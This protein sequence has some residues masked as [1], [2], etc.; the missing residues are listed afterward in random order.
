MLWAIGGSSTP[1]A[2][3]LPAATQPR[4]GARGLLAFSKP[5]S[6]KFY[7]CH[8]R[9]EAQFSIC[10]G[11][12]NAFRFAAVAPMEGVRVMRVRCQRSAAHWIPADLQWSRQGLP[13]A[14]ALRSQRGP[15][16]HRTRSSPALS[17]STLARPCARWPPRGGA[18]RCGTFCAQ[19]V[20]NCQAL[21]EAGTGL[22]QTP[23]G[24][25]GG[26]AAWGEA[27]APHSE[28]TRSHSIHYGHDR[29]GDGWLRHRPTR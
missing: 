11:A 5:L 26:R 13:V 29:G 4:A 2:P 24:L 14:S 10:Q 27:E 28:N 22:A 3:A 16:A 7:E 25:I 15:G 19:A 1:A 21:T 9:H 6:R 12:A 8:G 23:H 20:C 17:Q 18:L